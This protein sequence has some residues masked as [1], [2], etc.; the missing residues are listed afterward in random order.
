MSQQFLDSL[1]D[2]PHARLKQLVGVWRGEARTWFTPESAPLAAPVAGSIRSV[3]DGRFVLHEYAT[4]LEDEQCDGIALYG[5]DLQQQRWISAWV[6]SCHNGTTIMLS[7]SQA[8]PASPFSVLGSYVDPGGGP[9]WGW[10]TAIE[11]PAPDRLVLAHFNI[12]PQGEEY[13]AVEFAYERS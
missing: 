2:G 9:D 5:Y 3:L 10:R 11:L 13:L 1:A 12:T 6:D 4:A 7:H 8:A